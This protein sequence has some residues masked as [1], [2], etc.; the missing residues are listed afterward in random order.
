MAAILPAKVDCMTVGTTQSPSDK[1]VLH[2]SVTFLWL[3]SKL[4]VQSRAKR[5]SAHTQQPMRTWPRA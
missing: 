2:C 1:P 3:E 5:G 4:H